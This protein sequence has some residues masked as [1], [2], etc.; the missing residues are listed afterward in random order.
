M[1]ET[2]FELRDL[3]SAAALVTS[4][5]MKSSSAFAGDS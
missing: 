3:A 1:E 2:R 4:E 5:I